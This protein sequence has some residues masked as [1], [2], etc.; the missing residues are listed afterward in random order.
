MIINTLHI[1]GASGAGTSTIAQTLEKEYNYKWLDTDSYYWEKTDPPYVKA[2]PHSER[3]ALMSAVMQRNPRWAIS[4]SLCG[5][6]DVFIPRFNLVVFR[7]PRKT[8]CISHGRSNSGLKAVIS[9]LTI[10]RSGINP[11]PRP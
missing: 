6:G 8:R 10:A 9:T 4:G 3:V 2:L 11:T 5:W 7:V 1:V